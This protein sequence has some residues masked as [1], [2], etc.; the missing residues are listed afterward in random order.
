[1]EKNKRTGSSI[2]DTREIIRINEQSHF[3]VNFASKLGSIRN[4]DT[5]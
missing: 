3:Q 1:M 2:W 5:V 4:L